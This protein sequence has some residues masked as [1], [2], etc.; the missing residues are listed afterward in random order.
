MGRGSLALTVAKRGF[1]KK[2]RSGV[3]RAGEK[4]VDSGVQESAKLRNCFLGR[5]RARKPSA[6]YRTGKLKVELKGGEATRGHER[7]AGQKKSSG[8]D[9]QRTGLSLRAQSDPAP[10]SSV[11]LGTPERGVQ[12]TCRCPS[13]K[14]LGASG[15]QLPGC[16]DKI[17]Q[18]SDLT[19]NHSGP[20]YFEKRSDPTVVRN[21]GEGGN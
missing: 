16:R 18:A 13:S 4:E 2:K 5:T 12:G 7:A 9:S 6:N 1:K 10:Q 20:G 11:E 8:P 14:G 19:E 3:I 17:Q 21:P 15:L